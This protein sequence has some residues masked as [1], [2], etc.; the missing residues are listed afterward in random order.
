MTVLHVQMHGRVVRQAV[1]D[2]G[3]GWEHD[4]REVEAEVEAIPPK[5][6]MGIMKANME[7]RD[8]CTKTGKR[9][10]WSECRAPKKCSTFSPHMEPLSL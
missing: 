4:G 7:A 5:A 9:G 1:C 6:K 8:R 10:T 3:R 2:Q